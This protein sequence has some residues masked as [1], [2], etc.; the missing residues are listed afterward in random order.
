MKFSK[1]VLI[2]LGLQVVAAAEQQVCSE[3]E[4]DQERLAC[5]DARNRE[6]TPEPPLD[7]E[8]TGLA[9][10]SQHS[11]DSSA[12]IEARSP[13][14]FGTKDGEEKPTEFIEATIVEIRESANRHYL[15]LDN[16]QVWREIED[17][18][19]RFKE[20]RKVRITEGILNSYDLKMEG[21][22]KVIKV[23]RIR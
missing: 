9:P 2:F 22:N 17:T 1:L 15:R 16:G 10:A 3:I 13:E 6:A 19:L 14:R 8:P 7:V 20:G 5:Y 4:D 18:T 23:K 11:A 21:Q 12:A